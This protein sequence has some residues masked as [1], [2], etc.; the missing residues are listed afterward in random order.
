MSLTFLEKVTAEARQR[1]A[2]ARENGYFDK[3]LDVAYQRQA[4]REP[5]RLRTALCRRDRTNIIAEIKRASPSKGVIKADIDIAK[6]ARSYADGGAAAI[7]VLTEPKHF[8]GAVS[9]LV[10]ATKA[11]AI[12]TLRKDFIVDEYQI[13]EA[14]AAGASAILLIVAA[15]SLEELSSLH[16]FATELGLDVLVEV[17]DA[18]EMHRAIDLGASIIGVNNRDL[19]SL[20][21]SLDTSRR[22]IELRPRDVIIVA[23]SG[24]TSRDEIDEFRELGY[25]GFLIGETL[26]RSGNIVETLGGFT[27]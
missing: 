25:D 1:V 15:L 14:A 17:H 19:H 3:L 24:L 27:E 13:V 20:E 12:P 9:D 8:D 11:V 16:A 26:M 4:N 2:Q 23:E 21:V 6:L 5:N 22:L 10:S 7:S 18:T